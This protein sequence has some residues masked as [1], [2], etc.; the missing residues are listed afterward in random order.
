M[1]APIILEFTGEEA[2]N[3]LYC[4][5]EALMAFHQSRPACAGDVFVEPFAGPQTKRESVT[6][7]KGEG[8]CSLSD[9]GGMITHGRAGHGGQQTEMPGGSGYCAEHRPGEWRTALRGAA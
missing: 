7:E 5:I 1:F 9:D 4:L 6:A 2:L 8:G 3:D